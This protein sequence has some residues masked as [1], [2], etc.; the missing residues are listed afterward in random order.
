[1]PSRFVARSTHAE[2]S[3]AP[4]ALHARSAST[5]RC[6]A[7]PG[8]YWSSGDMIVISII[9]DTGVCGTAPALVDDAE[10][11]VGPLH[12]RGDELNLVLERRATVGFVRPKVCAYKCLPCASPR[13]GRS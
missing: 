4:A 3:L 2:M 10:R 5:A 11:G 12:G 6:A 9:G 7:K 1:M 13:S 8:V